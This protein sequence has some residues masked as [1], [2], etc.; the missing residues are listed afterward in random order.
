MKSKLPEE[1]DIL[2][3]NKLSSRI[4]DEGNE[5]SKRVLLTA[6]IKENKLRQSD[7]DKVLTAIEKV[8]EWWRNVRIKDK[9]LKK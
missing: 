1:I 4:Y 6:R 7:K 2:N 3:I 8:A 5:S 9:Y